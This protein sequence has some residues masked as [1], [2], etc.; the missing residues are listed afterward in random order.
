[1]ALVTGWWR[2]SAGPVGVIADPLALFR[3]SWPR[4]WGH[5]SQA[6]RP[7]VFCR[8]RGWPAGPVSGWRGKCVQTLERGGELIA[9]GPRRREMQ[10]RGARV[11]GEASGDVQ[12]SVAQSL[13]FGLGELAG[14]EQSLGPDDEVVRE[15]DELEPDLVVGEGAEREVAHP[16][17]FVVADVVLDTRAAA[18]V[19]LALKLGDRSGLVG[20][21]RLEAMTV[22]VSEG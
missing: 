17:V 19:A 5:A 8:R 6:W 13:G 20:E 1:M 2:M 15:R 18:V 21:D 4:V 22:V 10:C 7:E 16:G 12:H 14:Q 9:P 11:K 3:W